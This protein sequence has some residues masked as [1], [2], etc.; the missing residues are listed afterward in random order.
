[1]KRSLI[2]GFRLFVLLSSAIGLPGCE[3]VSVAAVEIVSLVVSPSEI[4]LLVRDTRQ[5]SA[6]ARGAS[7]GA[8]SD[9]SISWSTTNASVATVSGL[10][11]VTGVGVGSAVI[12]ATAEGV[13]GQA[14]ITVRPRPSI[15]LSTFQASFESDFGGGPT[16]SAEIDIT[17]GTE[18]TLSQ[19]Q[20]GT[21]YAAGGS[22]GWLETILSSGTAPATLTLRAIPTALIA[23]EH[24]ADV[25]VR[26]SVAGNSPQ[27]VR[28]VLQVGEVPPSI[29][30]STGV[31]SFASD[32]GQAD[33]PPQ[34]VSVMNGG[35]GVL[36]G[37]AAVFEYEAGSGSGWLQSA[38]GG[39]TAPTDLT[40]TVDPEGFEPGV[41]DALITLTAV[42]APGS[43][44]EVR[45]R[46][47]FGNPPPEIELP[48]TIET[49]L[50]EQTVLAVLPAVVIGNRGTGTLG[51]LSIVVGY[52]A[53]EPTGW[54]QTILDSNTAP[55]NLQL[56][57]RNSALLPGEYLGTVTVSSP[58]RHQL[59]PGPRSG[60]DRTPEALPLALDHYRDSVDNRGRRSVDVDDRR[61]DQ[62]PTGRPDPNR[63]ER[64][65]AECNGGLARSGIIQGRR[66]V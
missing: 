12:R 61:S 54:L 60:A 58:G 48:G 50:L 59:T 20:V 52:G 38:L 49:G 13:T 21:T 63:R 24:V 5:L 42:S 30:L 19:L 33:P 53:G 2:R 14:T 66:D 57:I 47:R 39:T 22:Q 62:R 37:I 41:Y 64:C 28:V 44:V 45:V 6:S 9:R 4:V 27:T 40:I 15:V 18:G 51:D 23:G 32:A 1:M 36:S 35:G 56:Q 65:E 3:S 55:T 26:S 7:G 17:N 34:V 10:G 8:L 16:D 46:Y 31:V 29:L 43:A 11:L 25:E